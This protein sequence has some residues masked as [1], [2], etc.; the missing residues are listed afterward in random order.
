MLGKLGAPE[1]LLIFFVLMM[2][3]GAKK[4]PEMARSFGKSLRIFRAE[5][6]ALRKEDEEDEE[7]RQ[8]FGSSQPPTPPPHRVITATPVDVTSPSQD[9]ETETE[10]KRQR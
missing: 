2:L 9:E 5:S 3:F 6:K 8:R 4:L 7:Q 1:L 10:P